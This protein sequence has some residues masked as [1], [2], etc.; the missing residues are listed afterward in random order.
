MKLYTK[1]RRHRV[2]HIPCT[3]NRSEQV[4]TYQKQL[5]GICIG[6]SASMADWPYAGFIRTS[7]LTTWYETYAVPVLDQRS[8]GLGVMP[9][10]CLRSY[11]CEK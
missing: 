1:N 3:S 9:Y 2:P 10:T 7:E 11:P 6:L 8:V 4:V 5:L